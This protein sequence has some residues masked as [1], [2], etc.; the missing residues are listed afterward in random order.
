MVLNDDQK[1]IQKMTKEIA[2]KVIAPQAAYYDRTEEFPWE[3][4][5][6]LS[7]MGFMGMAVPEIYD[8]A[9]MDMV[10]SVAALEEI[11]KACASTGTIMAV[12][13]SAGILPVLNFG[14]EEQK[15]EYLPRLATV[16]Y[17]HLTLPTILL[18]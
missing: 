13:N 15:K 11:S 14:S 18:V 7:E 2:Q 9:E 4:V 1:M 17:T 10:S 3:N 12:H 8:G 6:K 5:K 16:S